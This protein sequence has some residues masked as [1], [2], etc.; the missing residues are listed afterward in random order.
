[1]GR[2]PLLLLC[3]PAALPAYPQD[4][5]LNELYNS[6]GSDEWVELL[7]VDD[8]P[9]LRGRDLRDF[10]SGGSPQEPLNFTTHPLWSELRA[11]TIVVVAKPSSPLTEDTDPS[12]F[13]LVLSTDDPV[14]F[15][16]G[17]FS[18]A[19]SSDAIQVRDQADLHLFGISWGSNNAGSLPEPKVHFSGTSASNSSIAFVGDHLAEAT[20]P[21][22]W[23]FEDLSPTPGEGNS[24]DNTVWIGQLRSPFNGLGTVTVFPESLFH[25]ETRLLNIS[26][27]PD[28]LFPANGLRIILPSLLP[29]SRRSDDVALAGCNGILS[30]RNDTVE[31]TA[32]QFEAPAAEVRLQGVGAPDSTGH[33]QLQVQSRYSEYADVFPPPVLTAFG[34]PVSIAAIKGNDT[35]GVLLSPGRLTTLAGVLTVGSG[36]GDLAFLQDSSGGIGVPWNTLASLAAGDTAIIS[37]VVSQDDGQ[38]VLSSPLLHSL[39]HGV[40]SVPPPVLTCNTI[41][42]QGQRGVEPY[43]GILV[44]IDHVELKDSLGFP[45]RSWAVSGAGTTYVLRDT[46]GDVPVYVDADADFVNLPAPQGYFDIIGVVHQFDPSHPFTGGY[47]ILPRQRS[48]I[49]EAGPVILTQPIETAIGRESLTIT[50]TTQYPGT[51]R[52]RFGLT[53]QYELGEVAPDDI[54]RTTHA[55]VLDDVTPGTIYH[56]QAFSVAGAETSLAADRAVST[57]SPL[58]SSGIANV[59]FN[60]D[61]FTDL[62]T[63]EP[64]LGNEDLT[65][66]LLTR[67]QNAHRSVDAAL[68]NLGGPPGDAVAAGLLAARQRGVRVRVICEGDNRNADAFRLLEAGGI[69]VIDDRFGPMNDG[70]GLMHSKFLVI[71]HAGGAPESVWV[72]T[73]SWNPTA[74]QTTTDY[75]NAIEI[76]DVS[77]AGA[78]AAEFSEMWGSS[79]LTP[80]S[81]VSRFGWRKS[82]DTP[83]LFDIN[84]MTVESYFSPVDGS[85]APIQRVLAQAEYDIAF[86]LF[87]FTQE[88]IAGLL[89]SRFG[90]GKQVRGVMESGQQ[91]EQYSFL[92]AEGLDVFLEPTTAQLHHKYAIIDASAGPSRPQ[93]VITGSQ[94]WSFSGSYRN[95][96]NTLIIGSPR[97]A[98]LYIQEF[99]ARYYEAGGDDSI[100][101]GVEGSPAGVPGEFRLEQNFPNPFNAR[102]VIG[103]RLPAS[104]AHQRQSGIPE[105]GRV[106]L[107]VYDLLGQKVATLIDD[108]LS[109]G[110]HM[111]TWE[112][113]GM[114]SGVYFYRLKAES[115]VLTRKLILLR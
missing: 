84:G 18:F 112:P 96:E 50:W 27:T 54:E 98:N 10:S 58:G 85:I 114:A 65:L 99:A 103:Y 108:V 75:Q 110:T 74:L 32:I 35:A 4:V 115:S 21:V 71:D 88:D 77:L 40:D 53:R 19:G 15:S 91:P 106:I 38:T 70:E 47:R 111:V 81:L 69:P 66:R 29:W 95:D 28:S 61:V 9:D 86:C 73:G 2:I 7:V 59:Y 13:L 33:Y 11:G 3:F 43:E 80:D 87:S 17:V 1:M 48:D 34:L 89:A 92:R 6:G 62:S 46:T 57:A 93:Y 64:A 55:V 78:Y 45:P 72:W 8:L 5:L 24:P 105:Y 113:E 51:S 107:S 42:A 67:I 41:A 20:N 104:S 63:G 90:E 60:R 30:V 76:Q 36:P 25:G 16:D 26:Y 37:G 14:Y 101:V 23:E 22:F 49:M 100:T 102:T 83:H 82:D 31:V 56:V 68:Y 12:D 44:R 79:D 52:L 94:N 109:P 39:V 97:I